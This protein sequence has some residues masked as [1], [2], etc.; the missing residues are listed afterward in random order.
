VSA[1]EGCPVSACREVARI[2]LHP[3]GVGLPVFSRELRLAV[4]GEV[5]WEK[6]AFL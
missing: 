3:F 4:Y 1:V 6:T 5:N 2:A